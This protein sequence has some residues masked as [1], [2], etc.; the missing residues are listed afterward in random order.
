MEPSIPKTKAQWRAVLR[1]QRE[2]AEPSMAETG[3]RTAAA[4][5][6]H[7]G[8]RRHLRRFL[9]APQQFEQWGGAIIAYD[10]L[11]GEVD[12]WPLIAQ[13]P[14]RFGLPRVIAHSSVLE[15]RS[16]AGP[17]EAHPYGFHQ[18]D[19]TA[20]LIDDAMVAVVLTP[21]LAFD[22]AG[23]RLGF[24]GGF[25]D[26]LFARLPDAV[27]RIGICPDGPLGALPHDPH[28]MAMH[29]LA[30]PEGVMTVPRP[31]PASE[32]TISGQ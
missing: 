16:A 14:Q 3:S 32:T 30:T 27:L 8:V 20:P 29:Y 12:L 19:E 9:G 4:D 24:G 15:L 13:A 17:L 23:Y 1:A 26:R 7:D 5:P 10:P 22:A 25:Y 31:G 18:P 21:G 6:R 11:P 28:D 2:M